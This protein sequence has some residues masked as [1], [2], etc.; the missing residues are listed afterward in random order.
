M[1]IEDRAIDDN[2]KEQSKEKIDQ[3]EIESAIQ[4]LSCIK[5]K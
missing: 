3:D 4:L 1:E 2:L 5:Y